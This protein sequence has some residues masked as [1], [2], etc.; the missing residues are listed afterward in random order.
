MGLHVPA[1]PAPING[2]KAT[3][4]GQHSTAVRRDANVGPLLENACV[5]VFP[6]ARILLG[7]SDGLGIVI[8]SL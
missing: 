6:G 7:G 4:L 3:Y 2:P 5:A 8:S 1:T